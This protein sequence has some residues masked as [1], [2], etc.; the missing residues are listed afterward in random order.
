M[1][2]AATEPKMARLLASVPPEVKKIS[3]GLTINARAM[4]SRQRRMA[5]S[6]SMA[7]A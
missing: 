2:L 1:P 3:P 4:R 5:C 7:G 6:D